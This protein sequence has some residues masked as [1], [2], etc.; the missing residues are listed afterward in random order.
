MGMPEPMLVWQ[1]GNGP[2]TSPE[3]ATASALEAVRVRGWT[4]L[5]ID[6]V[7]IFPGFY[8]VEFN[9][10]SGFKGPEVYVNRD[11]GAIGPEMGPNLI[12]DT[13]YGSGVGTCNAQLDE[14]TARSIASSY[15]RG[16][17]G[18]SEIQLGD[19]ER[20]HGYW[21]FELMRNGQ[22]INQVNVNDCTRVLIDER[23]WQPDMQG[24]YA[25]NG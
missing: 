4:Q 19:S 13:R 11:S 12:W 23:M 9:D 1:E 24:T 17:N 14:A 5:S 25:P 15:L 8:E 16:L 10:T 21:E 7:H 6:E 2:T 18:S 3:Q 22:A 20:H